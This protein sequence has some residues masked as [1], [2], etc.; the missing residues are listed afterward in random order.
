MGIRFSPDTNVTHH[1]SALL[2]AASKNSEK[3]QVYTHET[4]PGGYHFV[5]NKRIAPVY[6]IPKIGY[7]LT[8]RKEGD[9]VMSKGVSDFL[10]LTYTIRLV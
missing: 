7:V 1:L 6:V 9:V 3:F 5:S 10:K 2:D 8:T 4:M